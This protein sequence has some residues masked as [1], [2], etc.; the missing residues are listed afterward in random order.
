VIGK[1]SFIRRFALNDY[2]RSKERDY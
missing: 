2:S 1:I